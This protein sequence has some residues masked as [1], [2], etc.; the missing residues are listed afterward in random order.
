VE[1][2]NGP[3]GIDGGD[4]F[5]TV[6]VI[7]TEFADDFVITDAGVFGGGLNVNYVN[8]E[9][10]IADG[11]EGNDRFFVQSTGNEVVT[12]IDG[13]LGSDTFFVRGDSPRPPALGG[14]D[15]SQRHSSL[16]PP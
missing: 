11:A 2:L 12:E 14:G 6:R 9:K 4:G 13:G 15:R 5:D 7:G 8:I 10:L 3:V 16:N 1:V